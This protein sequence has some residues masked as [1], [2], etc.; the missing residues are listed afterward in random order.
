MTA[1]GFLFAIISAFLLGKKKRLDFYALAN[2][3]ILTIAGGILGGRIFYLIFVEKTY[4]LIEFLKVWEPGSS[5]Q[6]GVIFA[7]LSVYIYLKYKK[8]NIMDYFDVIGISFI[9]FN[10]IKRI[11]CFLNWCC[12]GI[13][14]SLPWAIQV[15]NDVARHPTQ[16][17]TSIIN[18]IIFII[19]FRMYRT[20]KKPS[21]YYFGMT[22]IVYGIFRFFIE[23]I[24]I[25]PR[26]FLYLTLPQIASLVV[27]IFGILIIKFVNKSRKK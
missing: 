9:L 20:S 14:S 12:Y 27:I 25:N 26:V 10:A 22:F 16:I 3:A 8:A 7:L 2:S 6:G 15:G 1:L 4:A 13:E 11:G 18:L 19:L 5:I 17:Y 23:F 24:R 21:G